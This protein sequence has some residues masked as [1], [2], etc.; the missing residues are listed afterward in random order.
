MIDSVM[1]DFRR[2]IVSEVIRQAPDYGYRCWG[3]RDRETTNSEHVTDGAITSRR[4]LVP[5]HDLYNSAERMRVSS[6][7]TQCWPYRSRSSGRRQS[8]PVTTPLH[9]GE[10]QRHPMTKS[11]SAVLAA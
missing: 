10:P 7:G 9:N 5:P 4:P 11:A 3:V 8:S 2:Y 6:A 1:L